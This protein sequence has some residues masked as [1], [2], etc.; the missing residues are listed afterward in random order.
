MLLGV[1]L[2]IAAT[3]AVRAVGV[4]APFLQRSE[5]DG[6]AV[7]TAKVETSP[8]KPPG[9]PARRSR[10]TRRS[11][12][13]D[14]FDP[15]TARQ[16]GRARS[17]AAGRAFA[18]RASRGDPGRDFPEPAR[19]RRQPARR[20]RNTSSRCACSK[21]AGCPRIRRRRRAGSSAPPR[22]ASPRPSIGSDRC[23]RRASASLPTGRRPKAGTSRRRKPATRGP[24]TIWRSWTPSRPA[25]SRTMSKRPNGSA[26]R[27]SS[28]SATASTISRSST[29]AALGV[30]QDLRQSWMWFS[31]AA[32]QGDAD[33]A[34][35]RDE[36]AAK[37][38]PVSL[39]DR[40]GSSGEIQAPQARSGGKR[41]RRPAGR[42]GRRAGGGPRRAPP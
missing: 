32:Q 41:G 2:A 6:Q 30:G 25:T 40:G 1:A 16:A 22:S 38:D 42:L 24:P 27:A 18:S 14:G 26:R 23:S 10:S 35:K 12:G 7:K 17:S 15:S 36:V 3:V 13:A 33:A 4:R 28:A 34:K 20:R 29:P 31:L 8:L 39:A 9:L 37:M 5:L 21:A 11:T 19:R